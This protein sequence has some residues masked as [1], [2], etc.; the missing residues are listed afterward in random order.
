[1]KHSGIYIYLLIFSVC[2]FLLRCANPVAPTG[3][4]KDTTP[5]KALKCDPPNFSTGFKDNTIRIDFN[6]FIALKNQASEVNISPPLKTLPDLKLKGKS[7]AI[8]LGDTLAA[9]TTYSI[10]FG[11]CIS[12][13]TESNI[14]TGFSYVFSTGLYTDSLS[15]HGTVVNAYDL[16]PQKDVLA[17]LYVDHNDTIAFDSLPLKVKPYYLTKTNEKGEFL[18][19]NLRASPMKLTALADLNSNLIF[20]QATEKVAF[21]DSM[22]HPYYMPKPKID[23]STIKKDSL[24]A[25]RDTARMKVMD[26]N[27]PSGKS[28]VARD[29]TKKDTSA[30]QPVFPNH[31]LFLF[32]DIDSTQ[33][34]QKSLLVKKGL[35]LLIFRYPVKSYNLKPLN[36]DTTKLWALKEFSP[37]KDSL[38]L[39]LTNPKMDSLILMVSQENKVLD[40]LKLELNSKDATTSRKKD[41]AKRYLVV[42]NNTVAA[43]LNQFAGN[44]TLTFSYPI[45]SA[46]LSRI[47]LMQEKDTIKP[48]VYFADS[49]KRILSIETKWKEDKNYAVFIPDSAFISINGLA[50]DTI[51]NS[52]RTR[53]ARDFGNLILEV[54]ISKRPGD[55]LIQLLNEKDIVLAEKK[56]NTGGKVKFEYLIPGKFKV[57]A[58]YDHNHNG[59][60]DT[61]NFRKKIQPEEVFFLPKTLE[62][63]ANWDVEEKWTL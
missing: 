41:Q 37:H 38:F 15:L 25:K 60:W 10:D 21:S 34:I 27:A 29:S 32:D 33:R 42:T 45:S 6:E 48:K 31:L 30:K 17:M 35:V 39:W 22:V 55:Y 36:F 8:K 44:Y 49:L 4:P 53:L 3:G 47:R 56:I 23:S 14:L 13:I 16:S 28:K 5:P 62:I 57:K 1:M 18:F 12:D 46:N 52:F 40:T 59:R 2:S 61:G 58:I 9:N 50:N 51:R 43:S 11:K 7:L 63:R 20:D 24:K 54:D 19:H 26:S